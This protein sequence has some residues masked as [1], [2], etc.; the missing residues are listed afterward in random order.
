MHIG[1]TLLLLISPHLS[2]ISFAHQGPPPSAGAR[3]KRI[4]FECGRSQVHSLAVGKGSLPGSLGK[5]NNNKRVQNHWVRIAPNR[6]LRIGPSAPGQQSFRLSSS[7]LA[8]V[9]CRL[10]LRRRGRLV[11]QGEAERC[12]K[13]PGS[14]SHASAS[15]MFLEEVPPLTHRRH[16]SLYTRWHLLAFLGLPNQE[17]HSE[18]NHCVKSCSLGAYWYSREFCGEGKPHLLSNARNVRHGAR[19]RCLPYTARLNISASENSHPRLHRTCSGSSSR[20]PYFSKC[21]PT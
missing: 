15:A 11:S 13:A 4:C 8:G 5:K 12:H 17:Y 7:R 14:I 20:G 18:I 10:R 9:A 1:T 21:R 2:P 19:D 6:C 3:W 16:L